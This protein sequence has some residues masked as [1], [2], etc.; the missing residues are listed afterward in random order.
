[1]GWG[2]AGVNRVCGVGRAGFSGVCGVGLVGFSGVCA[3]GLVGF[4]GVCGGQGVGAVGWG[5]GFRPCSFIICFIPKCVE[6]GR[7]CTVRINH[8]PI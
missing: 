3:V 5:L 4:R 2:L 7:P 8:F 6:D 1:M